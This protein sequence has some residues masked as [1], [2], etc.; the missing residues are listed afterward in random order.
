MDVQCAQSH[1]PHPHSS[2]AVTIMKS[3]II[4]PLSSCFTSEVWRD[5]GRGT[6]AREAQAGHVLLVP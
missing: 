5:D 3:S 1:W 2:S 6:G 4:F